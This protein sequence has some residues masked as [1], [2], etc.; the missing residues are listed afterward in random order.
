MTAR[1]TLSLILCSR[2]DAYMGNARWRLETTLNYVAERVAALGRGDDVEVLVTDWGSDVPLRDVVALEPASAQI[3]SFV[4]VPPALAR[5]RQQDSPFPEVLALNAAARRARGNYIGRIDQDTLVG[6][7]F[8]RWFFEAPNVA[9]ETALLF[10]NRRSIPFR[11]TAGSPSL[12]NVTRFVRLFGAALPVWRENEATG[13]VFWTSYVGIWLA[14]RNLWHECG[15]YDERL[16]YYNWMETDMICR[17]RQKYRMVDLGELTDHDF[18]HLE[19]FHPRAA[20]VDR[21][22]D[23]W[24]PIVDLATP[25][26]V[27]RPNSEAWG[28]H[29]YDLPLQRGSSGA[30]VAPPAGLEHPLTEIAAFARLTTRVAAGAVADRVTFFRTVQHQVWSRRLRIV[31]Q[32][33]VAGCHKAEDIGCGRRSQASLSTFGLLAMA[34]RIRLRIVLLTNHEIRR[35]EREEGERFSRFRREYGSVIGQRLDGGASTAKRALVI[36]SRC[37]TIEGEL[38]TIKA[39][40]LAGFRPVVLL[41]DEQRALRPYYELAGVDEIHL[42]SEFLT[43]LDYSSQAAAV[44]G[45]C[46]STQDLLTCTHGGVRVGMIALCTTL[47]RLRL[48]DLDLRTPGPRQLLARSLA[49]SMSAVEEARRILRT[50]RPELVLS[51]TEYTPKGELFETCLENGLDVIAYDTAH[52][53]RT[54]MFKRYGRHNRD[55]HTT[56]LSARSWAL[57]RNLEWTTARRDR[58]AN[59]VATSY[60]TSDWFAT[61]WLE[62]PAS[63]MEPAELRRVL[64]LDPARKTAFIFPHMLWDAPVMWGRPLF[65]TYQEWFVE[66]VRAAC[67]NDQVNWVIK[68]HPAHV[69]KQADEKYQGEAAEIRVLREQLGALPPHIVVI[70]PDTPVSTFS[71]FAVMD[72]CLTVRGTVGVE[73]ARLGIPV[74]TAG[75]ARYA[76]LGFTVDSASR[77]EYLARLARIEATPPLS[78]EQRELAERFAYG[79]FLLRPLTL[80]SVGESAG[81]MVRVARRRLSGREEKEG[82]SPVQGR[83]PGPAPPPRPRPP[84]PPAARAV[85]PPP[86]GRV[87]LFPSLVPPPLL[88]HPLKPGGGSRNQRAGVF[89]GRLSSLPAPDRGRGWG[90]NNLWNLFLVQNNRLVMLHPLPPS[91][92]AFLMK[93][94]L[95]TMNGV[96]AVFYSH[97][98]GAPVI[99]P[100]E[101]YGWILRPNARSTART[102]DFTITY[103]IDATGHRVT[104]S[105]REHPK[106]TVL[107]VG[108]SFTFGEGV[109][110]S[111]PYPSVLAAQY[112]Q[113]V[114]VVNA[115]VYAWGLTQMYLTVVDTLAR[116]P[117]PTVIVVA[118]ISGDLSRSYLRNPPEPGM[119]RR[120]E[121]VDGA[122]VFRDVTEGQAPPP[123][124]A[125]LEAKELAMNRWMLGAMNRACEEKHVTLAVL[126][127]PDDVGYPPDWIYDLGAQ[128]IPTVDLTRVKYE[129]LRHDNHPSAAG[130]RRLAEAVS[131]S[132]IADM[133][134]EPSTQE[135]GTQR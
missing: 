23:K 35:R 53:S 100:D 130:H 61:P 63:P 131:K 25:P 129:Q 57:V 127:F 18:Y 60:A 105:P 39:L 73:A 56:T 59:E 120:L 45:R 62:S 65:S 85:W 87:R 77:E 24:N 86:T 16:I 113:D 99:M 33:L 42:W 17:L 2:N 28:L 4:T 36:S 21:Q 107:F 3:V 43:S 31:Q 72:Y 89:C 108:D 81:G 119:K 15:G 112:W 44:V 106:A 92:Y 88:L 40:Q 102:R 111:E 118:M 9:L 125:E 68:I 50:V 103:T 95:S 76:E 22:H 32:A 74:L 115:G 122:L 55:Q 70:P 37:P 29:E 20:W 8:L 109:N 132:I 79:L 114:T 69:W 71:L 117:L 97:S 82:A 46:E 14:H 90:S 58:L 104:P 49:A 11:F 93:K 116:K 126:L 94:G 101:R 128:H 64:S 38:C 52:R 123:V 10:A 5:E 83:A 110:D 27:I 6:E 80:E 134:R 133:L 75:P 66:T 135:S 13:H 41:E 48:G 67:R 96:G 121:F 7:R 54:L 12:R 47:R 124:D 51:D 34:R 1:R 98:V 26:T 78:D 30:G 84:P 91:T 19:H